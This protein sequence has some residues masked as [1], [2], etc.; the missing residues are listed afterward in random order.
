MSLNRIRSGRAIAKSAKSEAITADKEQGTRIFRH[1]SPQARAIPSYPGTFCSPHARP[2]PIT[3][4]HL[5]AC[6]RITRSFGVGR[7][8]KGTGRIRANAPRHLHITSYRS[9]CDFK[10]IVRILKP[11]PWGLFAS[12]CDATRW[13]LRLPF[14][15][16]ALFRRCPPCDNPTTTLAAKGRCSKPDGTNWCG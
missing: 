11:F 2:R 5:L 12:T 8:Y 7:T 10:G 13:T 6:F 16:W 1:A 4:G 9:Y 14:S 15:N 3:R